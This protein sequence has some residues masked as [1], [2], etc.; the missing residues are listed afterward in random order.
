[1]GWMVSSLSDARFF[2]RSCYRSTY[3]FSLDSTRNRCKTCCVVQSSE[4]HSEKK[5]VEIENRDRELLANS[6][7]NGNND[8]ILIRFDR[9]TF[10]WINLNR[11]LPPSIIRMN[12]ALASNE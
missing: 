10:T 11:F 3:V 7:S 9:S 5:L 6:V 4:G 1:M 12:E 2:S 8:S